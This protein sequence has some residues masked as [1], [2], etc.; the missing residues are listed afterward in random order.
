MRLPSSQATLRRFTRLSL[1]TSHQDLPSALPAE[2]FTLIPWEVQNLLTKGVSKQDPAFPLERAL[3]PGSQGPPSLAQPP[4]VLTVVHVV[5]GQR[6]CVV[7]V[8]GVP[9]ELSGFGVVHG[10]GVF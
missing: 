5:L 9:P 6:G 8:G 7:E 10:D 2:V 4:G 1:L 3:S